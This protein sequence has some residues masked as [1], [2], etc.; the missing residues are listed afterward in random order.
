MNINFTHIDE[1]DLFFIWSPVL[2]ILTLVSLAAFLI[3]KALNKKRT[4][5]AQAK[6]P[7]FVDKHDY[8]RSWIFPLSLLLGLILLLPLASSLYA[9]QSNKANDITAIQQAVM[10]EYGIDL[11]KQE[12]W[13]LR[14]A[15]TSKDFYALNF[16]PKSVNPKMNGYVYFQQYGRV[17][18]NDQNGE[19]VEIQLVRRGSDVEVVYYAPNISTEED[20]IELPSVDNQ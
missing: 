10:S 11:T 16:E 5:E 2:A 6:D 9:E 3:G 13:E 15:D 18:V 12:T 14:K 19:L 8:S 17:I 7:E 4:K 1:L 20:L